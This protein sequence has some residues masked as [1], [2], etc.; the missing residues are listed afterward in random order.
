MRI[1]VAGATGAIGRRLIP[2]LVGRG[3][4]VVAMTRSPEK[5]MGLRAAGAEPAVADAL[6]E[7]SVMK[8]VLRAEPQVVVHQLTAIPPRAE[9]RKFR[10]SSFPS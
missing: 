1:F 9:M 4:Q 3:H 2:M 8:L 10:R 7:S 6:E 5:I